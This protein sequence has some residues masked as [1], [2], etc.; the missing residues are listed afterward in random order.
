MKE[1]TKGEAT[2][3]EQDRAIVAVADAQEAAAK[4]DDPAVLQHLKGAGRWALGIAEKIGVEVATEA[5][6][7]AIS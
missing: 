1:A 3:R 5:F 6:K 4:G 7:K 2:T